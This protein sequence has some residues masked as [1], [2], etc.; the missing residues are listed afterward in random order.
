MAAQPQVRGDPSDTGGSR[1]VLVHGLG[2]SG[3]S[4]LLRQFREMADGSLPDSPV[5]PGRV[6]TVWLDWEDEQRDQPS[7]YAGADGPGLA[8]VLDAVQRAVTGAFAADAKAAERAGQAFGEY[9]QGTA[10]MPQYAARF[11]DVIA[12]SRQAGSAFTPA[13]AA[14][15]LKT[16]A[17][18]GLVG[19]G[20]PGGILGLTP[21][22]IAAAAQAAGN[23]SDAAVRAVTGRKPGEITRAEYDLVTD[24]ARE[25]TRRAAAAV[26]TAAGR[27]PL[28]V[29]LDTGEIIG[30]RAWGWLRRVMTQTGPQVIWVAGARFETEAEAGYDSPV[31]QFVRDIGDEHLILMSPTRFDDQMIRDYLARRTTGRSYT[32]AQIDMI[33]RYTKG[34]PLAVSLTAQL[35]GDGEPVEQVCHEAGDEH[36]GSVVSALA[37]RYLVHAE[38]QNYP[39]GDPRAGDVMKILGLALTFGDLREDP[40]LL[41]ALWDVEDPL[42]AFQDLARRH[43]FVLPLSRRLH[44]DVRDTLRT[45]LLDPYRRTRIREISQRAIGLYSARLSQ[46]RSRWPTLDDQLSHNAFTTA[47]QALLWHTLWADNQAGM[48]MVTGILPV[49][50]A[51]DPATADA[52]AAIADWFAGTFSDDQR[53]DL[54]LLTEIW[55]DPFGRPAWETE[56]RRERRAQVTMPGLALHP[57]GIPA[58]DP[59]IGEPA[60]RQIAI[61]ILRAR[62]QAGNGGRERAVTHLRAGGSANH[63][64]QA[65]AGHRIRRRRHGQPSDLAR[66]WPPARSHSH[67]P[68][69]REDRHRDAHRQCAVVAHLRGGADHGGPL[70][71]G[72]GRP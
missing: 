60:D 72:A 66:L 39:P 16:G 42:A 11:A 46:M 26:R 48:D 51:A 47:L 13:D 25:L 49:L 38:R 21:D 37:R 15:L 53:H 45:D 2:G 5:S 24:P 62:L 43:D 10:R 6:Q 65:A 36:P 52:A 7:G 32:D 57:P 1:V 17:S 3:K 71:G 68:G 59:V 50:E 63:Q 54:D 31:A 9:R 22:Q 56:P 8:T 29:L 61:M 28:V 12:Q 35:L 23:L 20:H 27:V 4:R 55:D 18:A 64:H 41:A 40:D 44:D 14:A 69:S 30:G 34:L 33:A 19:I 67:R 70:R 58:A